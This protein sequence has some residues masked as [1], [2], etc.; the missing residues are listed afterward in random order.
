M[1]EIDRQYLETSI[2]GSRRM[3]AWLERRVVRVS[4]KRVQRPMRA[5]G[6]RAIYRRPSTSRK[7]GEHPVYPYLVIIQEL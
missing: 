5:M 7:S 1:G 4:G 2:C 3:R 6:L